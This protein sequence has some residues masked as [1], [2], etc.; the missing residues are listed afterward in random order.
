M[1]T[2]SIRNLLFVLIS[3]LCFLPCRASVNDSTRKAG[4]L[5]FSLLADGVFNDHEFKRHIAYGY[6]LGG[7]RLVPSLEFCFTKETSLQVGVNALRYWGADNYPYHMYTSV[8]EYEDK[9]T[10]KGLHFLPFI[11][12][13]WQINP[14]TSLLV[15]NTDNT[16]G[17]G[18]NVALWNPELSFS[19]DF[20]EG[21]Q[22]R[23]YG[24]YWQNEVWLNWQ[25]FN[26]VDDVDRESFLLGISGNIHPDK[27][28]ARS[29]S[30]SFSYAFMWQHHGGE[31]D[32]LST[33]PLDHWLNGGFGLQ[34]SLSLPFKRLSLLSFS[35]D[36]VY[37]K[38]LKNDTW[39]FKAGNGFLAKLS[40]CSNNYSLS[41]AY[42]YSKDMV[43]FYAMPFFSNV[44]QRNPEEYYPDNRLIYARFDYKM[45]QRPSAD[46]SVYADLYYKL[47]QKTNLCNET[48][49]ISLSLGLA[50]KLKVKRLLTNID[51]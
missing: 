28:K 41:L 2:Q 32:T 12:L 39:F 22:L 31:L 11:R 26:F 33:L 4:D 16:M 8:P 34:Y 7:V 35:L 49:D 45:Y 38:S 42:Y 15:G 1:S 20:E 44:A 51:L 37:S 47:D 40:A 23:H 5:C 6:T 48:K 13:N 25:N 19:Q 36:W 30:L 17:H 43:S 18:L 10:Q 3:V 46:I 14:N 29:H 21:L 24:R 50:I 27:D 9:N